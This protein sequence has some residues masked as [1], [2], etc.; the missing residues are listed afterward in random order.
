MRDRAEEQQRAQ[1][2]PCMAAEPSTK[3]SIQALSI[4]SRA[5]VEV[6]TEPKKSYVYT[7]LRLLLTLKLKQFHLYY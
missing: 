7:Y 6:E 2:N 4:H 3:R 5:R 1:S